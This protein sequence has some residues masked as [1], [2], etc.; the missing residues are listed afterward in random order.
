MS[1][2]DLLGSATQNP[3]R[4]LIFSHFSRR[5]VD[6]LLRCVASNL[7][8]NEI[9]VHNVIFTSYNTGRDGINSIGE[10]AL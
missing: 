2:A 5:S 9:L 6:E 10:Y 4:I 7:R 1:G 3:T 8:K